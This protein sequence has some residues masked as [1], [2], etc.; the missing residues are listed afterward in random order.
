MHVVT[1]KGQWHRDADLWGSSA[2]SCQLCKPGGARP[3]VTPGCWVRCR[4]L[5]R[6]RH[7]EY[8]YKH[9]FTPPCPPKARLSTS[10]WWWRY[11]EHGSPDAASAAAAARCPRRG[12]SVFQRFQDSDFQRLSTGRSGQAFR[13]VSIQRAGLSP[14]KNL[15][16][17]VPSR[18][19]EPLRSHPNGE[20]R[21]HG[22]ATRCSPARPRPA[23]ISGSQER[24]F[25]AGPSLPYSNTELTWLAR[26]S[27]ST[28]EEPP[29]A[30]SA[31]ELSCSLALILA[32][33]ESWQIMDVSVQWLTQKIGVRRLPKRE[34]G[35]IRLQLKT[36]QK[37]LGE[38]KRQV[39][40]LVSLKYRVQSQMKYFWFCVNSF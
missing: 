39:S 33:K 19:A 26:P 23:G 22:A 18:K 40:L 15:W 1:Q 31:A 13:K 6:L 9:E 11:L 16:P 38:E 10:A 2:C 24:G 17:V 32:S 14:S 21:G 8:P 5:F 25:G 28:S 34:Q 3:A 27:W 35:E 36:Y 12:V 29:G 30:T 4:A 37:L 7:G 20:C